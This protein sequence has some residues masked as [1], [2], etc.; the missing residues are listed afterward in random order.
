M[1]SGYMRMDFTRPNGYMTPDVGGSSS[2]VRKSRSFSVGSYVLPSAWRWALYLD[3]S[4]LNYNMSVV[5]PVCAYL[6]F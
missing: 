4:L 5:M 6:R 3:L 1:E 2:R